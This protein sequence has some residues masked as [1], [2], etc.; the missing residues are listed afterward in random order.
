MWSLTAAQRALAEN[1]HPGFYHVQSA[2]C[3]ILELSN[4]VVR[5]PSLPRTAAVDEVTKKP[6]SLVVQG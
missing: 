1:H 2:S 6:Q 5:G 4:I 3:N